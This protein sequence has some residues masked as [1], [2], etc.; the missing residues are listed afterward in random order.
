MGVLSEKVLARLRA[1]AA[2]T[3]VALVA[4]A[5]SAVVAPQSAWAADVSD[6]W[7]NETDFSV[8]DSGVYHVKTAKGWYYFASASREC[9]FDD[10]TVVLDNNIDFTGINDSSSSNSWAAIT[11]NTDDANAFTVGD[12]DMPFSGTFNGQGYTI[13]SF[14]NHRDGL[15]LQVDCGFFGQTREA[16]IKNANFESCYVGATY[17]GGLVAGYAQDT[18][19]LNVTC[20]NCTAS[21]IPP[22]NVLNLITNAGMSGGMICGEANGSTLYNCEVAGGTVVNNAT[23]GVG[24][25]GGQPLYLGGLVGWCNDTVIEYSRVTDVRGE[26]GA[27]THTSVE[28]KYGTAVSVASYSE[29][30][31]GGIVGGMKSEDS[32]SKIVDCYCTADVYSEAAIYFAVGLGLGVTRGYTGGIVGIVQDGDDAP[33]LI[34]RVSYAGNLHSYNYN[35]LLLGIPIIEHDKYMGGITGRGGNNATIDQAYFMRNTNDLGM[36]S[37]TTEDI[38]AV[39]TT[40]NGGYSD[41]AAYGPRDGSYADRGFWESCGFDFAGG[42]LRNAGYPFTPDASEDEWNQSHYNKWV[43]DYTRGIPVHGGSIKATM[44]FPGSGTV[45]IGQ[46]GLAPEDSEQST[47]DPYDFAVQGYEQGDKSIELTYEF[48]TKKN[49]SWA[50]DGSNQGFRFMGWYRSRDVRVND[51]AKDHSLFTQPNSTLNTEDEGLLNGVKYQVVTDAENDGKPDTLTVTKPGDEQNPGTANYSD[52]DLYVAYAQAQVLLHDAHGNVI[53]SDGTN[54]EANDLTDDWY[55]YEATLTL[56]TNVEAGAGSESATLIGWTTNQAYKGILS[57]TELNEC[58]AA[59]VFYEAGSPYAV[60]APANLYPVYSDYISNAI[61]QYEG[62]ERVA[63]DTAPNPSS[64]PGFGRANA[65][66]GEDGAVHL[67]ITPEENS[68]LLG[69]T[70]TTRFLGWYELI[71]DGS[72]EEAW[73]RVAKASDCGNADSLNS[74][75]KFYDYSL[76]GVDLTQQHTYMARFEYNVKYIPYAGSADIF[77]DEWVQYGTEFHNYTDL[78]LNSEDEVTKFLTWNLGRNHE[79]GGSF[80]DAGTSPS[81]DAKD[82][83]VSPGSDGTTWKVM[84]PMVVHAHW[85]GGRDP[86]GGNGELVA[87][88]DF[89]G[90]GTIK[91]DRD[92]YLRVN[93]SITENHGYSFKAWEMSR[94]GGFIEFAKTYTSSSTEYEYLTGGDYWA[95]ARMT[96]GVDFQFIDGSDGTIQRRYQ[97]QVLYEG[98]RWNDFTYHYGVEKTET[99][100]TTE[101][102]NAMTQK[103]IDQ[104]EQRGY[105]FLG[106]IDR[107]AVAAGELSQDE[108]DYIFADGQPIENSSI[109]AVAHPDRALPYL[110]DESDLCYRTMTLYPVYVPV[111]QLETTTNI[112]QSGVDTGTYNIPR[113]PGIADASTEAGV[114]NVSVAYNNDEGTLL[115]GFSSPVDLSYDAS[116]VSNI[117]ITV[118]QSVPISGDASDTYRFVSLSVLDENDN[119]VDTLFPRDGFDG[120]FAYAVQAGSTYTFRANYSPVPVTV[121]YHLS[122]GGEGSTEQ[123]VCEV[124]D[125]LPNA[126]STPS[127]EGYGDFFYGWTVG[128]ANGY[129]QTWSEDITLVQPGVDRVTGAMHLW[130]VYRDASITVDSNIDGE[131]GT[132][133]RGQRVTSDGQ[134]VEIWAEQSVQANGQSYAFKGW[135]TTGESGEIVSTSL[136]FLLFGDSRF[137]DPSATYTAVY[138]QTYQVR[139]HDTDGT[140]IYTQNLSK[141]DTLVKQQVVSVPGA[142]G[143][144]TEETVWMPVD[145]EPFVLINECFAQ[146][147]QDES[148]TCQEYFMTWSFPGT[149]TAEDEVDWDSEREDNFTRKPIED[150]CSDYIAGP[151]SSFI[152]LYPVTFWFSAKTESGENYTTSLDWTFKPGENYDALSS[153]GVALTEPYVEPSLAITIAKHTYKVD[154][155][156]SDPSIDFTKVGF[157]STALADVPVTL[158]GTDGFDGPVVDVQETEAVEDETQWVGRAVFTFDGLLEITKQS[159]DPD[160]AGRIFAIDVTSEDDPGES[161]TVLVTVDDELDANGIYSGKATIALPYGKYVVSEDAEWAWRYESDQENHEVTVGYAGLEEMPDGGAALAPTRVTVKNNFIGKWFDGEDYRH[162]VFDERGGE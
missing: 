51:I 8:D 6:K 99:D 25:L 84:Y 22:N 3:A 133:H 121:T 148:R 114:G 47:S 160:A 1:L 68:T 129:A 124:G 15:A 115:T 108:W 143:T 24:A 45:T 161:R 7:L 95:Y 93:A 104:G 54:N 116:G 77:A 39:K 32:G 150:L 48:T 137:P 162:N 158:Y 142:D 34:Q 16:T 153:V 26:D 4:A 66:I 155:E 85:E 81:W 117:R 97:E 78:E 151:K 154:Y 103:A 9:N 63:P 43:M 134:G 13:S 28:N 71:V 61:V 20:T 122:E 19:F 33:N 102:A 159:S 89:P 31:T 21:I 50:A 106:W 118:D 140:V 125:L 69:E 83:Q 120:S 131:A 126:T 157:N 145:I 113:D 149:T 65:E 86:D 72:G 152:D 44:D 27:L 147:N 46:T 40:Y 10:A 110:L 139:Y 49:E 100:F 73:V 130:P 98:K 156:L 56:P 64:R 11:G 75:G 23:S 62:Y 91:V 74:T 35:I 60:T 38:Y 135:S 59:G 146:R 128:D 92:E 101:G 12:D 136:T 42:T 107:W 90:S 96:A 5:A 41:G 14:D 80:T 79:D 18:F 144:T 52:N 29:V 112:A 105:L 94:R 109:T 70:R 141:G 127:F 55:D 82:A 76:A 111:V 119:E 30:F 2:V 58:K 67:S 87:V 132:N 37:S 138:E 57:S 123:F 88:S 17:R 36:G 53:N